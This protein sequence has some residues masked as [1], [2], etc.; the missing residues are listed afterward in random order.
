M[1]SVTVSISEDI[2]AQMKELPEMNWSGFMRMAL[3]EKVERLKKKQELLAQLDSEEEH[4]Q[5]AVD[6]VRKGRDDSRRH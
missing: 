1:V 5:W 4:N 2:R 6:L 3:V